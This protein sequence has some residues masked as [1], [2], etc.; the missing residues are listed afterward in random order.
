M[1]GTLL[2]VGRMSSPSVRRARV[3]A[4]KVFDTLWQPDKRKRTLAY[5]WLQKKMGLTAQECH[6]LK[7]DIRQ[8][9]RVIQLVT[10]F[11]PTF[12]VEEEENDRAIP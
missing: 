4:H 3:E 1:P 12:V 7:F 2:A 6:I 11:R 10:R 9:Y 8:C 5:H